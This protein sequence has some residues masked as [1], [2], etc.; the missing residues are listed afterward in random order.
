[1]QVSQMYGWN[2]YRGS[3]W[4]SM[5]TIWK[6]EGFFGFFRGNSATVARIMPYAAVQ[7][8]AFEFYH[9]VLSQH[10]FYSDAPSPLKRF[11]AGALAGSTSV[12]CT[13]PIDLSRTVLAVRIAH[14]VSS[15]DMK[16]LGIFPTL[17]SIF[18]QQGIFG[19]Y[20]GMYPTLIGVIPYAGISF[21]SFGVFKRAADLRG[22]SEHAPV[23]TSLVCGGSAGLGTFFCSFLIYASFFYCLVLM[24][25]PWYCP[26]SLAAPTVA[27]C[28]TYPFDLVRRRL[29]ALHSPDMMTH[30]E[31]VLLFH[32]I[33]PF[34]NSELFLVN[35]LGLFFH[36]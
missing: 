16:R 28:C 33:W 5:K 4:D 25:I 3:V 17:Y 22:Y 34:V 20:R 8:S 2:K 9:R 18:Q 7:Y 12:L 29:Q 31:K 26:L 13:Y 14:D 32:F 23:V 35:L 15:P 24:D 19:L 30:Q 6:T 21:L 11:V 27:Q 36:P 10:V 1:M